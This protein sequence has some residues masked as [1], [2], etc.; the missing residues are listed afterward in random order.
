MKTIVCPECGEIITVA[1]DEA[2][3]SSRLVCENCYS[4]LEITSEDPIEVTVIDVDPDE[5]D[6]DDFDEDED[7][8][9]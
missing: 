2:E 3:L 9:E 1:A 7:E 6:E 5:L 8:D 4:I